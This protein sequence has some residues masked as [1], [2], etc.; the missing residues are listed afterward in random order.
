MWVS[1]KNRNSWNRHQ[2]GDGEDE[3][4]AALLQGLLHVRCKG[5]ST[6]DFL[7]VLGPLSGSQLPTP[8]EIHFAALGP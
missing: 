4:W 5:P 2:P 3:I 7:S 6:A 8:A 1:R